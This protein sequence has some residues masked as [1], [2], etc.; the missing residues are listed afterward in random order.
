MKR[1]ITPLCTADYTQPAINIYLERLGLNGYKDAIDAALLQ[2]EQNNVSPR[3]AVER[4]LAVIAKCRDSQKI[5]M[6][7]KMARLCPAMTWENFNFSRVQTRQKKVLTELSNC[8]WIAR[9]ENI[10][11]YGPSGLGKTHVSVALGNGPSPWEAT[12]FFLKRQASC[13][14]SCA[15]L[16]LRVAIPDG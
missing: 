2:C 10:L 12:A 11:F 15:Q 14:R 6:L 3:Q 4:I 5:E 1:K 13:L 16:I 9:G 7:M 8:H